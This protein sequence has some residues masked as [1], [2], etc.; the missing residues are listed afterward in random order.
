MG[1]GPE[2]GNLRSLANE[3]KVADRVV[4]HPPVP[5][6]DIPKFA[7]KMDCLIL[8]LHDS[9]LYE[10]GISLNK[11]YE[12]MASGRPIV[13]AGNAKGNPLENTGGAICVAPKAEQIAAA[14]EQ[15]ANMRPLERSR[16]GERNYTTARTQF[17][18]SVLGSI[19]ATLLETTR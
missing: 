12:Y 18:F 16:M 13:F 1:A 3:L 9:P 4:F 19:L 17:D 14:L 6:G 2:E 7:S 8:A 5:P 11:L 10:Y 15:M